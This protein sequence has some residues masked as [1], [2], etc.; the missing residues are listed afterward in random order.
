MRTSPARSPRCGRWP[1][2]AARSCVPSTGQRPP[3]ADPRP[4]VAGKLSDWLQARGEDVPVEV[5]ERT[6][7]GLSQ[8]TWLIRVGAADAVLRLPTPSSGARAI[9]SQR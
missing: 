4:E 9:L 6:T 2:S 1:G 7:V 3:V 5:L 8:E